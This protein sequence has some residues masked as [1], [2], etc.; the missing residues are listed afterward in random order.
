M[1]HVDDLEVAPIG[2]GKIRPLVEAM[3]PAMA[4]LGAGGPEAVA[5]AQAAWTRFLAGLDL[6]AAP[7]VRTCP[8]CQRTVMA[9]AVRCDG[10]WSHLTPA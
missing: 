4:A 5:V 9:G 10:C 3:K 7:Q 2:R 8:A 6:G 1:D